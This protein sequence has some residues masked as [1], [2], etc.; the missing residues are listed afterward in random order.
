MIQLIKPNFCF[1]RQPLFFAPCIKKSIQDGIGF[2]ILGT[3]FHALSVKL[4][5]CIPIVWGILDS[6]SWNWFQSPGFQIPKAEISRIPES[7]FAYLGSKFQPS[8]T[9]NQNLHSHVISL[10]ISNH[11]RKYV[12]FLAKLDNTTCF[13]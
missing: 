7:G 3:G 10:P 5:F 4:R 9:L 2:W 6:L 8:L 11:I 13:L 1:F 12:Y